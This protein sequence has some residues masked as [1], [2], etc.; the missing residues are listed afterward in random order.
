MT[1]EELEPFRDVLNLPQNLQQAIRVLCAGLSGGDYRMGLTANNTY[2][3]RQ[4]NSRDAIILQVR[5]YSVHTDTLSRST[6]IPDNRKDI[7]DLL[8]PLSMAK[9]MKIKLSYEQSFCVMLAGDISA[10]ARKLP[11][12]T[13]A[14]PGQHTFDRETAHFTQRF[15]D[16]FPPQTRTIL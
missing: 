8:A 5:E 11:N 7:Y 2:G 4:P 16:N 1:A 14:P 12:Y 15:P 13:V 10:C 3:R 9:R 6:H